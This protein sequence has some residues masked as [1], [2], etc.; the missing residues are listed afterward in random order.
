MRPKFGLFHLSWKVINRIT[1]RRKNRSFVLPLPSTRVG[2]NECLSVSL[3]KG[4]LELD[5]NAAIAV[6]FLGY[7]WGSG[8][9]WPWGSYPHIVSTGWPWTDWSLYFLRCWRWSWGVRRAG[10]TYCSSFWNNRKNQA[11]LQQGVEKPIQLISYYGLVLPLVGQIK[12]SLL[13]N[14]LKWSLLRFWIIKH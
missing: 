4:N 14:S 7:K 2:E 1:S 12:R 5:A 9:W 6:N 10:K 13:K 8:S 11:I 3:W